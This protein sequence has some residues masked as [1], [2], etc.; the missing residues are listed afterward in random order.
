MVKLSWVVL[1]V[2]TFGLSG[3]FESKPSNL[4]VEVMAKRYWNDQLKMQTLFPIEEAKMLS[5]QK[6]GPDVYVAQVRYRVT[7]GLGEVELVERLKQADQ[8]GQK[9]QL[10]NPAVMAVLQNL[11]RDFRQG[12]TLEF[13]K[14]LQF[15]DGSRGWLLESE[16]S[17]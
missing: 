15:R 9:T 13:I 17:L 14:R 6:E 12:E 5:A 8:A 11:P 7:A 2:F 1:L 4:A 3:C 10:D 16:L